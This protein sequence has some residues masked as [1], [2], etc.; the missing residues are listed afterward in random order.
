VAKLRTADLRR[1]IGKLY[2]V[3]TIGNLGDGQL[4]E[5]FATERGEGAELAFAVL[6]ERHGPMVLRVCHSVLADLHDTEDAFQATFLVLLKKARGLWVRD[7]LGPWLHQ[8]AVRTASAARIAAARRR[9]C[10]LQT[11]IPAIGRSRGADDELCHA[12][13]EEIERLP[14]RFRL[15]L[16]LC[17][18][19]ECSHQQAARHLGWPIGTVKSRLTRGR[20]RLRIRLTRRGLAPSAGIML[21]AVGHDASLAIRLPALIDSTARAAGH[22]VST[23][24][25]ASASMA[26][27]A[28][29]VQRTLVVSRW[30]KTAMITLVVGTAGA[31]GGLFAWQ[32]A[33]GPGKTGG[34]PTAASAAA[35]KQKQADEF[36]AKG[37]IAKIAFEGTDIPADKIEPKLSSRVGQT[38]N[39][40]RLEAD[41]RSL[42]ATKWFSDATYWIDETPPESGKYVLIFSLKDLIRATT[43]QPGNLHS[44]VSEPGVVGKANTL[45]GINRNEGESVIAWILPDR[46]VVKK[47][48]LVC[49]LDSGMLKNQLETQSAVVR[50]AEKACQA[51]LVSVDAAQEALMEYKTAGGLSQQ[52]VLKALQAHLVDQKANALSKQEAWDNAKTTEFNIKSR[53]TNCDIHAPA[54][55]I[56]VHAN[57]PSRAFNNRVSIANGATVRE[58][59]IIFNMPDIKS[60]FR[61]TTHVPGWSVAH[62][63]LGKKVRIVADGGPNRVFTGK[64]TEIA[65][66]SDPTS[67]FDSRRSVYT[68]RISFD[69]PPPDLVTD[70]KVRVEIEIAD[71]ENVLTVPADAVISFQGKDQ[72]AIKKPSG[73][74]EWREVIVGQ[75][76]GASFEVKK[77][78]R[79]GEVVILEPGKLMP[80]EGRLPVFLGPTAP[81]AREAS[82]K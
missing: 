70:I 72:V 74:L 36:P 2:S 54:D 1:A 47:G 57:D 63:A 7:S 61:V 50:T 75:S 62:L 51:A 59:Q 41:L 64:I 33:Q 30:L 69:E 68:T 5:R 78:I 37:D 73:A 52:S 32:G 16:V 66:Y 29:A 81:A 3:G 25:I 79:A 80:K 9:R 22:F 21:A 60:P 38:L 82:K 56:I 10:D 19:E 58:R 6:V 65:P 13:H 14:E 35:V 8:V 76:D 42:L 49:K 34:R 27:L 67:V 12:L 44:I 77:G 46:S 48:D 18:L 31:G 4:L 43:V 11:A 15:P 40:E 45:Y 26:T 23:R 71:L 24:A 53:V 20:E 28:H 39:R 55:G 17:D